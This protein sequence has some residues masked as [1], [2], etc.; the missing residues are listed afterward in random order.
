VQEADQ[1]LARAEKIEP[2][3]PRLM[4]AKADIYIKT[5]RKQQ[6]REILQRYLNAQLTPEDPPRSEALRLLR[7]AGK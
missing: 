6:A 3:S 4:L 2:G 5:G 1:S 7:Q